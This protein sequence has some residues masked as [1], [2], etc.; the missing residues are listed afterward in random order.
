M[1]SP[2]THDHLTHLLEV[3]LEERRCA[4]EFDSDGL[5]KA[6]ETKENLIIILEGLQQISE[7]DHQ[8]AARIRRENRHNACLL[9]SALDWIRDT[10]TFLGQKSVPCTYGAG[11]NTINTNP[12]GRLLSGQI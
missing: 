6:M 11:A 4:V 10:M 12:S 8:L 3:I 9:K 2:S 7:E 1:N 5:L